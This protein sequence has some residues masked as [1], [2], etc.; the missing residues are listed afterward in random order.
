MDLTMNP[1]SDDTVEFVCEF[2]ED[3]NEYYD[4]ENSNLGI[5]KW[6]VRHMY[7]HPYITEWRKLWARIYQ[8]TIMYN[9]NVVVFIFIFVENSI[10][11]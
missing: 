8:Y 6:A 9:Y 4:N 3:M 1:A 5:I 11:Q 2:I 7:S 10:F